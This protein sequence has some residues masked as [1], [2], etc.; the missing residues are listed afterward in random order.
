MRDPQDNSCVT[1][2]ES[3][4]GSWSGRF[5]LQSGCCSYGNTDNMAYAVTILQ[6][7]PGAN[8]LYEEVYVLR[9]V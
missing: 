4:W 9:V 8:A 1:N 3:S 6:S 5:R 7:S 2:Q